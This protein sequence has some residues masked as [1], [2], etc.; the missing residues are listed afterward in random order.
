VLVTSLAKINGVAPEQHVH[1]FGVFASSVRQGLLKGVQLQREQMVQPWNTGST[2][3]EVAFFGRV[4][5][6]VKGGFVYEHEVQAV[7]LSRLAELGEGSGLAEKDQAACAEAAEPFVMINAP[8]EEIDIERRSS[9][10]VCCHSIP[11]DDQEPKR[12]FLIS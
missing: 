5:H 8:H 3:T 12:R 1:V 6:R 2:P 7:S 9:M 4:P 11:A 10:A